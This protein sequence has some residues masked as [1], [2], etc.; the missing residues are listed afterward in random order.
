M[1]NRLR[2]V[3][4]ANCTDPHLRVF[5]FRIKRHMPVC[6]NVCVVLEPSQ[7]ETLATISFD[8]DA[9]TMELQRLFRES[10]ANVFEQGFS[11]GRIRYVYG[12]L[13]L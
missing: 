8:D 11:C 4:S 12:S 9:E 7:D 6:F 2:P 3:P 5:G 10:S 1:V 13:S